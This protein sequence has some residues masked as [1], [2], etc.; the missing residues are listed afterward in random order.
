MK[1]WKQVVGKGRVENHEPSWFYASVARQEDSKW[2]CGQK[3]LG[4][5]SWG[6]N[7]LPQI[8]SRR[9][10]HMKWTDQFARR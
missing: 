4:K 5:R 7:Y 3:A 6:K 2:G 8:I 10:Y 9:P 1:V